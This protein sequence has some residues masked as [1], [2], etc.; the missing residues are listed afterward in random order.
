ME[1]ILNHFFINGL[2]STMIRIVWKKHGAPKAFNKVINKL[3]GFYFS[4]HPK[5]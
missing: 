3:V 1:K 2:K 5:L 4:T